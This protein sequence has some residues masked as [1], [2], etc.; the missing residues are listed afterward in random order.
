MDTV[1][2]VKNLGKKY[3]LRHLDLRNFGL[4]ERLAHPLAWL[5]RRANKKEEFWALQDIN[6][7]VARG[8]VVGVIGRNGSGKSTLLKVLSRITPPS[9]GEAIISGR[10]SSLLEVGVG[11]HP[12]LTGRENI[13]LSG[14]IL[15]MNRREIAKRFDQI[16]DF[17]GTEQFLDTQV[18]HYSSGMLVRLGFAVAAYMDADIMFVDE[19]LA[20]GDV[21]FQKKCLAKIAALV[22]EEQRTIF[23]VSHNLET[24][25]DI[26]TRVVVM[27]KGVIDKESNDVGAA[28]DYYLRN[29][30]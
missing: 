3:D 25:R 29:I 11:F 22:K 9:T 19:V 18:K 13:F 28:I 23:F 7:S 21:E 2:E 24:V 20:V 8:E 26:C 17:S 1:I 30:F 10:I 6:F 16:V 4:R 5:K 14:V 27:G 12:E 15:G